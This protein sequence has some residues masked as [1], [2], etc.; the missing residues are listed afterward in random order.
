MISASLRLSD[1]VTNIL[2]LNKLEH[3]TS[4]AKPEEFELGE[5]IRGCVLGLCV[6]SLEEKIDEKNLGL[7]C[8]IEDMVITSDRG[9][10]E[11]VVN[12]LI[13]NA[14]KYTPENGQIK[15][16]L[17]GGENTAVIRVTD[18]GCGIDR[19]T[20]AHIFD[21]FYQ[22]DTSHASEGNGLG[23]AMVK[24]IVDILGGTI[25]VSS[26]KGKGSVFTIT[27]KTSGQGEQSNGKR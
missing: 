10:I 3:S 2:K 14:V 1:L 12:N 23:L 19:E 9:L 21:K 13:S 18:T 25:K 4:A 6:P 24:R 7:D 17:K 26:E 22:G 15:V 8:D 11:T 16:E 20:G 27:L 5:T